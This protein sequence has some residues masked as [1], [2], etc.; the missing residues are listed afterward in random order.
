MFH[1]VLEEEGSSSKDFNVE[2]RAESVKRHPCLEELGSGGWRV[3]A[4]SQSLKFSSDRTQS[5]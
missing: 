4:K 5:A 1:L 2:F 3:I